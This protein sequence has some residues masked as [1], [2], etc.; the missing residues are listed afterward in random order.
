LLTHALFRLLNVAAR[1]IALDAWQPASALVDWD[2]LNPATFRSTS[3]TAR[4]ADLPR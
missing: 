3:V 4:A 2:W 1:S